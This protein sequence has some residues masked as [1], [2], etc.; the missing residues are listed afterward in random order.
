MDRGYRPARIFAQGSTRIRGRPNAV[1][2]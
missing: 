2:V 1:P